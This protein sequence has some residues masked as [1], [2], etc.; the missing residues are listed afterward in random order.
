[1]KVLVTGG[2]GY[3]G[4]HLVRLLLECGHEVLVV[5]NLSFGGE[6]LLGVWCHPRFTFVCSDITSPKM[7]K[8]VFAANKMDAVV[9][10]AA[11]VGDPACGKQPEI[12]HKV[13]WEASINLLDLTMASGVERFVFASTCSNYGK[14]LDPD[15]HVNEC[16]SLSP[17]SLYAKQKVEFERV[18]LN[19][20]NKGGRCSP[21]SLRF[22]TA[23]GLSPRMRFDLTVN[24]FSKELMLGRSLEVFG[25]TFWR[26]Y[27]HVRDL[28]RA[29]V[30]VLESD[31]D[32]VAHSIF[33]I[34]D[35][36][37][38][39]QKKMIIDEIRKHTP[40]AYVTYVHKDEDPRD[41]R[42]SFEK[43]HVELGFRISRTVPDGIRE[44]KYAIENS[45]VANPDDPKHRNN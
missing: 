16:T 38:N 6:S 31:R 23:Y 19:D 17:V 10:L 21:T 44:I 41:Y 12:A 3:V 36:R 4:S 8:Q 37:E 45:L 29:V 40:E 27:C 43:A 14:M 2:A 24:E 11:I 15:G 7:L 13:N 20:V 5:D 35:T 9:H 1:M 39:Y 32:K 26:P 33:N 42:V 22:A 28:A 34:G 18:L 25:E 30:V